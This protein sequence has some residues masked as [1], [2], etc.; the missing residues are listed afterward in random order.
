MHKQ[1]DLFAILESLTKA[2]FLSI[3]VA[4]L[5]GLSHAQE[6]IKGKFGAWALRCQTSSNL[7]G[8][9][10]ALTQ[11]VKS[12]DDPKSNVGVII[13][14]AGNIAF[15]QAIAPEGV[16]LM[17]GVTFKIDQ[18]D[19]GQLPFWKCFGAGCMA[20]GIIDGDLLQKLEN[21]R[22]AVIT[23]YID[24]DRGLRHLLSLDGFKEGFGLLK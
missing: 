11:T 8:E 10:C 9:R 1:H 14:K 18:S 4:M 16:I 2:A 21:G 12:D 5:P 22:I 3:Y 24:P 15:F 6:D 19:I 23:I 20:E 17:R 13:R 7:G